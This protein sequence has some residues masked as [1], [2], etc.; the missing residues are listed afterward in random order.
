MKNIIRSKD[1]IEPEEK[2]QEIQLAVELKLRDY[3]AG[4]ALIGLIN[5]WHESGKT[6][7][8]EAC[9]QSYEYADAML[10]ARKL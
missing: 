8:E 9:R 6:F 1:I 3:F 5:R 7:A 4:Q 2:Q 10:E